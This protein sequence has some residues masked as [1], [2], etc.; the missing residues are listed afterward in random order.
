MTDPKANTAEGTASPDDD[1]QRNEHL[2]SLA[3]EDMALRR[4]NTSVDSETLIPS[5]P[6][7]QEVKPA[8]ARPAPS[9]LGQAE[10]STSDRGDAR[11]RLRWAV[12]IKQWNPWDD[13]WL[14]LLDLLPDEDQKEVRPF[15]LCATSSLPLW[16]AVF[17]T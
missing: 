11:Y 7:S 12:N 4:S 2:K 8:W 14:F 9:R 17:R 16:T 1:H 15:L 13:E 10:A 3:A 6:V 5:T